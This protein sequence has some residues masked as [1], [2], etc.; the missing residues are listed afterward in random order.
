MV[1]VVA[2]DET[3]DLRGPLREARGTDPLPEALRLVSYDTRALRVLVAA[4]ESRRRS[5]A[6]HARCPRRRRL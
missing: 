3:L 2:G 4:R 5:P 1:K 6:L